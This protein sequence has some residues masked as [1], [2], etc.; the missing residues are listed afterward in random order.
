MKVQENNVKQRKK[1]ILKKLFNYALG[2][3]VLLVTIGFLLPE[4]MVIPVKGG[5]NTDW[6]H[7]TFWYEPWGTSGVHKGIDIFAK[8][9]TKLL[10][11]TNGIVIFKGTL[12]KGGNVV[13]VLGSKWRVHY[14]AH[15]NLSTVRVGS[16][17]SCSQV[18]GEVG[19]SG[20]AKG[21]P[22]HVHYSIVTI[23]PYFWNWDSS[24]QGWKKIFFLN[25]SIKLLS[26]N[27]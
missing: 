21:K 17:V 5:K 11:A 7:Q 9:G 14:Y 25:P 22:A 16:Y 23:F 4:N 13:A 1:Y 2:F 6:N 8:K 18:I 12:K 10:S 26:N 27:T 3:F 15:L 19:N 24:T 20:N